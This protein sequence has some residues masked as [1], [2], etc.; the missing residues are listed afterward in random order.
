MLNYEAVK[1]WPFQEIRQTLTKRDTM[2]YA[3]GVGLSA[4]PMER[5]P[6][7]FTYEKELQALPSMAAVLCTPGSWM[8]DP[9][10]GIDYLKIV[11]GEQ[12]VRIHRPLPVEG[13]LRARSRVVAVNDKGPG[14]GA[15]IEQQRE[16]YGPSGE[17]LATVRQVAFGRGE[18][19]YSQQPGARSDDAPAALPSVPDRAPDAELSLTSLPQSA[20]IYRLSGDYNP[21]HSD[22]DVAAKAGFPRPILHG[23]CTYGMATHAVLKHACDYDASRIKRMAVRFSS[24]VFPGETVKFQMWNGDAG[25]HLRARVDERDVVV[26][27]N[28]WFEIQ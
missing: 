11:H 2:L 10:S 18:G 21:L 7:R 4:D 25:L 19:G 9:K 28:G 23:L 5:G 17:L 26:L 12:D 27:N 16:V 20:L 8:V 15:V 14:K 13:E 6:L 22:P 3:L 24:P 1:N